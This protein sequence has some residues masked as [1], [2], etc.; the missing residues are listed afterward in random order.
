MKAVLTAVLL[1]VTHN[2]YNAATLMHVLSVKKENISNGKKHIPSPVNACKAL[3]TPESQL[4]A[5]V[6]NL[7]I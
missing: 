1:S 3:K 2:N 6:Y 5:A 4:L 7:E